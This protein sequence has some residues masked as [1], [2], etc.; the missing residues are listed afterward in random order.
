LLAGQIGIGRFA[1]QVGRSERS[2]FDRFVSTDGQNRTNANFCDSSGE[3]HPAKE[4]ARRPCHRTS[5]DPSR[6]A[7]GDRGRP[8]DRRGTR[9]DGTTAAVQANQCKRPILTPVSGASWRILGRAARPRRH[10]SPCSAALAFL[11]E[12]RSP[13]SI[14]WKAPDD[15]RQSNSPNRWADA[16]QF[17]QINIRQLQRLDELLRGS[18]WLEWHSLWKRRRPPIDAA[19]DCGRCFGSGCPG[20]GFG[21]PRGKERVLGCQN[22]IVPRLR[23]VKTLDRMADPPGRLG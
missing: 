11:G 10:S 23:A 18:D 21:R 1:A 16:M 5:R 20:R 7:G 19:T 15:G 4:R 17:I 14:F 8:A 2:R 3:T 9:F 12:A 6:E 13:D 22:R